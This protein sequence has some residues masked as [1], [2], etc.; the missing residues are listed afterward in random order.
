MR[1]I[2]I[3]PRGDL[4]GKEIAGS[5]YRVKLLC[6]P[7]AIVRYMLH[8]LQ[9][10][11]EVFLLSPLPKKGGSAQFR[12]HRVL[13]IFQRPPSRLVCVEVEVLVVEL[14]QLRAVRNGKRGDPKLPELRVKHPLLV[15]VDRRRRLV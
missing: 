10:R 13:Y 6:A 14:P 11:L 1:A 8:S 12:S 9:H 4:T 5:E 3:G 7:G 2:L 15:R